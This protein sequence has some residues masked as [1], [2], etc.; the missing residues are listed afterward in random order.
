[1]TK[2]ERATFNNLKMELKVL[3]KSCIEPYPFKV[4]DSVIWCIQDQ[5]YFKLLSNLTE[6]D[7]LC[8]YFSKI[9]V[10]PLYADDLLWDM[11]GIPENKDEPP[12]LRATGAFTL[13]GVPVCA[14][15]CS[16]AFSAF[17]A[18]EKLPQLVRSSV[19]DFAQLLADINGREDEWFNDLEKSHDAYY[20]SDEMR[21][22]MMLHQK[23]YGQAL[24]FID[25]SASK[26]G[27]F[28]NQG[29][30]LFEQVAA[31]CRLQL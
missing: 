1:M 30:W 12:S 11:L 3:A 9:L 29:K 23:Q 2:E 24:G 6:K 8:R 25:S 27:C 13:S 31:Y 26:K 16:D 20:Q 5:Y 15:S 28:Q 14:A 21:L 10:K 22:M 19:E 4:K 18:T 17:S 7:G